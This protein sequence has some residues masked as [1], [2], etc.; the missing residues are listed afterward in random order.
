MVGGPPVPWRGG[1]RV[2]SAESGSTGRCPPAATPSPQALEIWEAAGYGTGRW[3][4]RC[5]AA[6]PG[7]ARLDTTKAGPGGGPGGAG[8][9]RGGG[10]WELPE[11]ALAA[12]HRGAEPNNPRRVIKGRLGPRPRRTHP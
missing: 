3:E 12:R 10:G 2:P 4:A 11:P 9:E 5:A 8:G 6:S 1:L 7:L